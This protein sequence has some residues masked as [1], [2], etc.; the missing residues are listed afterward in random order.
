[1]ASHIARIIIKN[2]R[3]EK[4]KRQPELPVRQPGLFGN[5]VPK[6]HLVNYKKCIK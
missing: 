5:C 1:M 4:K 3:G 2:S 6:Q